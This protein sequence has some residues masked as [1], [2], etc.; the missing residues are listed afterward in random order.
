LRD[1]KALD[2]FATT[3]EGA[4]VVWQSAGAA[5]RHRRGET[6]LGLLAEPVEWALGQQS[7]SVQQLAAR[8]QW[9]SADEVTRVIRLLSEAGLFVPYKP[10]L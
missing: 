10:Q 7:F 3:G 9:L 2:H 6:A 1:R 5:L 4:E 8:Y